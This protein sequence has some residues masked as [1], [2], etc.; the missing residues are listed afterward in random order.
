MR[1]TQHGFSYEKV[2]SKMLDVH[3][4]LVFGE[5]E[6]TVSPDVSLEV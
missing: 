2:K 5:D 1:A 4:S 6:N 3:T